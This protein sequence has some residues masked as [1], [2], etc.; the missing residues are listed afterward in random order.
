MP[1]YVHPKPFNN[2]GAPGKIQRGPEPK[3]DAGEFVP[4]GCANYLTGWARNE[5]SIQSDLVE[6]TN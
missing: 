4:R 5:E 2:Y 1:K 3:E 6:R